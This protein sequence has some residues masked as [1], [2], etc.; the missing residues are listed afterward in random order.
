MNGALHELI[1]EGYVSLSALGIRRLLDKYSAPGPH[2]VYSLCGLIEDIGKHANLINRAR[3]IEARGLEYDFEPIKQRARGEGPT[4]ASG[5]GWCIAESWHMRMDKLC[6][7]TAER[8]DP[9]D[10]PNPAKFKH[11][12]EQLAG[13]GRHVQDWVNKHIAHAASPQSRSTLCDKHQDLSLTELWRAE[14]VIVRAAEFISLYI[15]AGLHLQVSPVPY[16]DQFEDLD[17][18][19]VEPAA[20][21][22]MRQAWDQHKQEV[23]SCQNWFW[24]CPLSD[25]SDTLDAIIEP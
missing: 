14:R 1:N 3:V 5:A 25:E 7:V 16:S 11:L 8:R 24:D 4:Y 13:H 21:A 15:V 2:D 19:F 18:P 23:F 12:L 22:A 20:M 9:G 17:R 6:G 10:M